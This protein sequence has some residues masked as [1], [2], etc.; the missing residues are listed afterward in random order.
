[1]YLTPGFRVSP[2]RTVSFYGFV[3]LVPYRRVNDRPL[4]PRIAV[5]TG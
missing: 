2:A 1:M 3:L 5:L 4:G